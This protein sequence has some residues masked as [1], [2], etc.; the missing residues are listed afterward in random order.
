MIRIHVSVCLSCCLNADLLCMLNTLFVCGFLVWFVK[1][2]FVVNLFV[3]F[4]FTIS[5]F[6]VAVFF[7]FLVS[8]MFPFHYL[9]SS[10]FHC[11]FCTMQRDIS[12]FKP[13]SFVRIHF[14]NEIENDTKQQRN[15]KKNSNNSGNAT[16]KE[17]QVTMK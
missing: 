10:F 17:N 15:I 7:P 14:W 9:H 13:F 4:F 2:F 8:Y 6:F 11:A 5:S 1:R 12:H 16:T 3:F